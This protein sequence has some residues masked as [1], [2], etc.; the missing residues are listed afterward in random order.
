[1]KIQTDFPLSQ[2]VYYKIGGEAKFLLEIHNKKDLFDALEFVKQNKIEKVLPIGLGSNLLISDK[3][4]DGAVL[5]FVPSK[6][7]EINRQEDGLVSVF[8]S[9]TLE[10]LI[11]YSFQ[12][13]LVGIEWAGGLPSTIGA[14][15]RGN[16]GCFGHEIKDIVKSIE[17]VDLDDNSK[18]KEFSNEELGFSYRSS[19]IKENKRLIVVS[20]RF[21]LKKADSEELG[22]ARQMY[23]SNIAYREKNHPVDYPSCG[24]VF[25]NITN[26]RDVES[27]LSKWPDIKDIVKTK[28]HNKISMGYVIN[29]L[30]FSGKQVGGAEVSS[31]HANYILNKNNASFQDVASLIQLVGESFRKEFGF[32]PEPEVEIIDNL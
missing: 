6:K 26:P 21:H 30:G 32:S 4:F 16:V 8:S 10:D 5:W 19:I 15:V 14:A 18:V 27:I 12:N 3:G 9:V 24:S 25:K 20:G 23:E 29:R 13:S 11:A 22:K 28:W 31:K 17:A 7:A 2:I 1:M